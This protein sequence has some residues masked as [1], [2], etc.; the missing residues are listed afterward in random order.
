MR[1]L[2]VG[3]LTGE[4]KKVLLN[5]KQFLKI[6]TFLFSFFFPNLQISLQKP[7]HIVTLPGYGTVWFYF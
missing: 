7:K 6:Q 2:P 5:Q 1:E 4:E 3:I